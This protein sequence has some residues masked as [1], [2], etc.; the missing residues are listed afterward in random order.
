MTAV[1]VA[2]WNT[3][4]RLTDWRYRTRGTPARIAKEL[5]A[6]DADVL[7]SPEAYNQELLDEG[8]ARYI[9]DHGYE[10]FDIP[11]DDT[12][13]GSDP[14]YRSVMCF[15]TRLPTT[16]E[17][18]RLGGI[19]NA[20]VATLVHGDTT[21][22]IVG[23]HMHDVSEALRH[24][25]LDTLIP[26]VTSSTAST[27]VMGDWN[28]MYSDAP[29]AKFWRSRILQTAARYI[30]HA[31]V[32]SAAARIGEMA[33]GSVLKRFCE[34]TLCRDAD[35]THQPTE[36]PKMRHLEWMPSIPLVQ[37]DHIMLSQNAHIDDF[38]VAEDGGSDH[39]AI[40]ATIRT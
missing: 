21:L 19:R 26:L 2:S 11:N 31:H 4:G 7:F 39:R 38:L 1:R 10:R 9:A 40:C 15:Y 6:L 12:V 16:Y 34:E 3:E 30:P 20:G 14:L 5:V 13:A 24:Q 33:N 25:M 32:R 17:V 35:P 28:A 37:I 36:T 8:A 29:M 18:V 22:R 27:I 23:V